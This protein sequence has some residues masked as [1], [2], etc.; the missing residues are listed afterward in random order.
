MYLAK[1]KQDGVVVLHTSN[2]YLD[3][4]SVL[5]AIQKELPPGSAGIVAS[6][7][8]ADGSYSQSSSTVVI[9]TKSEKALEPYR[10]QPGVSELNDHGLR[11][12]T[13]DYS[14]LLGPFMIRFRGQG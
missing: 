4:D 7:R 14:D 12:W 3:L 1:L 8:S 13:D 10:K 11:S 5:S 6:D 2:R 9:F